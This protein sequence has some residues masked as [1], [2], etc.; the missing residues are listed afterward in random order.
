MKH[1][2]LWGGRWP[3]VNRAAAAA[4]ELRMAALDRLLA[5]VEEE[6]GPITVEEMDTA[7]QRL[8]ERGHER[9]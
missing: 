4:H 8:R 9:R 2:I 5:D 3:A 7:A 1:V 6:R